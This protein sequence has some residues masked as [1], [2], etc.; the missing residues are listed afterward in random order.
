MNYEY[1]YH[2]TPNITNNQRRDR[3]NL[4]FSEGERRFALDDNNDYMLFGLDLS[5]ADET[6]R[7][8][9]YKTYHSN[10]SFDLWSMLWYGILEGRED[11]NQ[12]DPSWVMVDWDRS[13]SFGGSTRADALHYSYSQKIRVEF[14]STDTDFAESLRFGPQMIEHGNVLCLFYVP[15]EQNIIRYNQWYEGVFCDPDDV[16]DIG[17]EL[18]DIPWQS[19]PGLKPYCGY[20]LGTNP[21][22]DVNVDIKTQMSAVTIPGCELCG[23]DVFYLNSQHKLCVVSKTFI[24]VDPLL[25]NWCGPNCSDYTFNGPPEAVYF[26]EHY[27]VFDI[28]E[29]ESGSYTDMGHVKVVVIDPINVTQTDTWSIYQLEVTDEYQQTRDLESMTTPAVAVDPGIDSIYGNEDDSLLGVYTNEDNVMEIFKGDIDPT[30]YYHYEKLAHEQHW[31]GHPLGVEKS[32]KT[33][34]RPALFVERP[35]FGGP[36]WTLWFYQQ[37]EPNGLAVAKGYYRLTSSF[38][39]QDGTEGITSFSLQ[40]MVNGLSLCD[41]MRNVSLASYKGKM[42]AAYSYDRYLKHTEGFIFCPLADGIFRTSLRD[43]NDLEI[44]G[45]KMAESTVMIDKSLFE[46]ITEGDLR[47]IERLNHV[48]LINIKRLG[49]P[50]SQ[51]YVSCFPDNE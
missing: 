36:K 49:D 44:I 11:P 37:S 32:Y 12:I 50:E 39:Y 47:E 31:F 41:N 42:R 21:A 30:D 25:P 17:G 19:D 20:M 35:A 48:N 1:S 38:A 34:N 28:E 3:N 18:G 43:V 15:R 46:G 16:G 51:T 13:G 9:F 22:N 26:N 10:A 33:Y 2:G 24:A 23:I 29:P 27:L 6:V 7:F 45:D 40:N 4:R 5:S 14:D 8:P